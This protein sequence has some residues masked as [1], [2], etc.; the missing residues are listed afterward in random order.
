MIEEIGVGEALLN[1]GREYRFSRLLKVPNEAEDVEEEEKERREEKEGRAV[2]RMKRM[3]IEANF[4]SSEAQAG[5]GSVR[6]HVVRD[7]FSTS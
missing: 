3:G 5:C 4:D 6:N 7:L 1:N 2:K